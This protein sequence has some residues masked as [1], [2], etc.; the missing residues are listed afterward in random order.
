MTAILSLG[1]PETEFHYCTTTF[2]CKD[3]PACLCCNQG[4]EVHG[5]QD[6]CLYKLCINQIRLYADK[7]FPWKYWCTLVEGIDVSMEAVIG[8]I[9]EEGLIELSKASQIVD[10]LL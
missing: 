1:A 2:G 4:L 5:I 7:W 9:G 6:D 8:K 10:I 3:H